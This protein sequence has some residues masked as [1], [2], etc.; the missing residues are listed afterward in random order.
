[1]NLHQSPWT[2]LADELEAQVKNERDEQTVE[3]TF[4]QMLESG[5]YGRIEKICREWLAKISREDLT[6]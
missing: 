5:Q 6:E 2:H 3:W 4:Q 1:M